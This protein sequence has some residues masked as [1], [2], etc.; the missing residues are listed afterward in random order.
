MSK[1]YESV[2]AY[3]A[4]ASDLNALTR[5]LLG[6]DSVTAATLTYVDA[7]AGAGNKEVRLTGVTVSD[8]QSGR[9]YTLQLAGNTS[10][11]IYK[12]PLTIT[13]NDAAKYQDGTSYQ[14]GNGV[15]YVGLV[16][17]ESPTVLS[18]ALA[19]SGSSQGA[20]TA[21]D[22]DI[23]AQGLASNNYLIS[24][25]SG[26][27]TVHAPV[28]E[29]SLPLS[30]TSNGVIPTAPELSMAKGSS[31]SVIA[32]AQPPAGHNGVRSFVIFAT[33]ADANL[34]LAAPAQRIEAYV[35]M[36]PKQL[37]VGPQGSISVTVPLTLFPES[38][39]GTLLQLTDAQG[40]ALPNWLIFDSETRILTIA[41]SVTPEMF[42]LRLNLTKG[43]ES[44]FIDLI[45]SNN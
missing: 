9:N 14:G 34:S 7:N 38:S 20:V 35:V 41:G 1:T 10:S 2:L 5:Q 30:N 16:G 37:L 8:G 17:A 32:I 23:R 43:G 27:L 25:V 24:F 4:N 31:E 29:P 12:A 3:V 13:A 39:P 44:R 11:S 36:V 33:D 6:T 40:K 42:P 28:T 19:Y 45:A 18:G 21:G 26:K 15:R 22:Y